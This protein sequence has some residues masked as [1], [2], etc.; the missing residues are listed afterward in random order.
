M[1][2]Y[3]QVNLALNI[4]EYYLSSLATARNCNS[5][6]HVCLTLMLPHNMFKYALFLAHLTNA[7]LKTKHLS[8]TLCP[9]SICYFTTHSNLQ[10]N[11]ADGS[12]DHNARSKTLN[13]HL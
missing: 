3:Q 2:V 4:P 10:P 6:Q 7:S 8:T 12:K 13:Y 11:I 1:A 9:Q 5:A